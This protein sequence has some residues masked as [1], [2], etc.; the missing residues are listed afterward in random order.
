MTQLLP[1][2]RYF[3]AIVVGPG[4]GSPENLQDIGIVKDLWNVEDHDLIPIFGVCLGLQSLGVEF[5]AKL[6]KLRVVKHGQVSRVIHNGVE[7]F[8]GV[9]D[10]NGVRY[11]SLHVELAKNGDIE[12]L[13]W[14]DDGPPNGRVVMAARHLRRPF[15][16]V[17]YHP[18]SVLTEG[19]GIEVFR[20]FWN[21]AGTWAASCGKT[22]QS[23]NATVK[24]SIGQEWPY[25][26]PHSPP[27]SPNQSSTPR[28]TTQ[29]LELPDVSATTIA[30]LIGASRESNPF[31]FLDSAAQPGRYS[32][33]ASLTATSPQITYF[34]GD[35]FVRVTKGDSSVRE[36]LGSHDIWSWIAAFMRV[37]KALGGN[38]DIPFWGGMIGYLSYEL[39]V[40]TLPVPLKGLSDRGGN[41]NLHAD[42]NLIF[43]ERSIVLDAVTGK[44]YVQSL[45]P[46]DET[47]ILETTRTLKK[48]SSSTADNPSALSSKR[49]RTI[50]F[51]ATP[52]KVVTPDKNLYK[53]RINLAKEHLF[54]GD[55][56]EL[57]LTAHTRLSLPKITHPPSSSSWERYKRLRTNNP[58]PFSAYL[59]LHPST[60]LS[61]SPER[62]LSF[63]RP[64]GTTCQLRPIKGTLRKSPGVTRA[65]AE[66]LLAGNTKEVA[67][68]LMIADLIRHD[69]Y[70]VLGEDVRV[71]QFCSVEE[72]ETLWQLVSVIEGSLSTNS[73]DGRLD[74]GELGWEVLRRCLPPG[75]VNPSYTVGPLLRLS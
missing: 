66:N 15:W 16:A 39:G 30:E 33:V 23:W 12:E 65:V 19:G 63:S 9:R 3:S 4:P 42:V 45:L 71:K 24:L 2:L 50:S 1:F 46:H 61:S 59:R 44:L 53:S 13:A 74:D 68:N 75:E 26:A 5:G 67:E 7:I 28:V 72:Y 32:I 49:R 18:E 37:R 8:R 51:K 10:V 29:I 21:L 54:D 69:L 47:W 43:V 52:A 38:P 31:L 57:C 70:G 6:K 27:T 20:N 58:A 64:P 14:A 17:Q 34:V 22:Q 73:A 25:L 41:L 40:N 56:Y 11:H 60:L 55:S 62:F 35:P 36:P 48:A